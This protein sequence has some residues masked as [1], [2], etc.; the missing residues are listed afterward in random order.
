MHHVRVRV[1]IW[2]VCMVE[3]KV[4]KVLKVLK[5]KEEWEIPIE[6]T[7]GSN[8]QIN[9][10]EGTRQTRQPHGPVTRGIRRALT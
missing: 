7:A 10:A 2:S 1:S 3:M 9:L 8:P 4:L 5:V 6:E